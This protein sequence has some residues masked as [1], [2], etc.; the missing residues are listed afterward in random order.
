M[1]HWLLIVITGVYK[2]L[3]PLFDERFESLVVLNPCPITAAAFL[4]CTAELCII[5]IKSRS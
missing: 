4:D 1:D 2:R 5:L 3:L